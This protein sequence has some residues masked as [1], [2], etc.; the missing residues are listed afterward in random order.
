MQWLNKLKSFI[1]QRDYS[2]FSPCVAGCQESLQWFHSVTGKTSFL[3]IEYYVNNTWYN[4]FCSLTNFH[5]NVQTLKVNVF[6]TIEVVDFRKAKHLA[7]PTSYPLIWVVFSSIIVWATCRQFCN[8]IRQSNLWIP[9]HF[10]SK[11][12]NRW[13]SKSIRILFKL[14]ANYVIINLLSSYFWQY[15]PANNF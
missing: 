2:F 9:K 15:Y 10:S 6:I 8:W 3:H 12:I 13:W 4:F 11:W 1:G 7:E 14:S 5:S